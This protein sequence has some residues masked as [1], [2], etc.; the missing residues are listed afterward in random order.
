M[1]GESINPYALECLYKVTKKKVAI[2]QLVNTYFI[3]LE[4]TIV[5][6]SEDH[7]NDKLAKICHRI[8][9]SSRNTGASAIAEKFQ[10]LEVSLKSGE[11]SAPLGAWLETLKPTIGSSKKDFSELLA[12]FK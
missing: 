6:L 10:S 12:K 1:S 11:I 7:P 5:E 9:G 4:K 2:E 8:K 3:H